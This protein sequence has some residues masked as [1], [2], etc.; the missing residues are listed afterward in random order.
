MRIAVL[1][2]NSFLARNFIYYAHETLEIILYGRSDKT[3]SKLN[4]TKVDFNSI[5]DIEKKVCFDVDAILLFIGKVGTVQGFKQPEEFINANEIVLL[6]ILEAYRKTNSKALLLY[7]SSRL[8]FRGH[9]NRKITETS[10]IMPKSI[11]AITKYAAEQYLRL[12]HE[13]YGI[14]Y[15]ILRICAPVGSLIDNNGSYGTFKLFHEQAHGRKIITVFGDGKQQKTFTN[16]N[17][18]CE[19]ILRLIKKKDLSARDY[20]LGG[21]VMSLTEIAEKIASNYGASVQYVPWPHEY[22]IVDGGTCIFDSKR[23]DCEFN[24]KY[25][26]I[27]F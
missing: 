17:D 26:D 14:K 5:E 2:C 16:I 25:R 7:P 8:I 4:Y 10:D 24:M 1:G 27:I 19:A 15:V 6:N 13:F 22:K 11:Y 23:F 12:Y 21:K 3:I 18:V 9:E 20:N